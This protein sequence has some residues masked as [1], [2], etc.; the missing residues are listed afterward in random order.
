MV[1]K[2]A[3]SILTVF[4]F[5]HVHAQVTIRNMSLVKPDANILFQHKDNMIK[6]SGTN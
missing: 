6:V 3:I 2:F 1:M 4:V 5:L